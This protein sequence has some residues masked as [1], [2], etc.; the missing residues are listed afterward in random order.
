MRNPALWQGALAFAAGVT[1][2]AL[3]ERLRIPHRRPAPRRSAARARRAGIL[4]PRALARWLPLGQTRDRV[5]N[6]C[7]RA[8]VTGIRTTSTAGGGGAAW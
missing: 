7:C 3:A 8:R 4:D 2:Q 5:T 1:S 6:R